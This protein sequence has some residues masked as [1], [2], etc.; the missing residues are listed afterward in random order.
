M[1]KRTFVRQLNSVAALGEALHVA[2]AFFVHVLQIMYLLITFDS[3]APFC[4]C[5]ERCDFIVYWTD[6]SAIH[7]EWFFVEVSISL[8]VRPAL[9][10]WWSLPN[11][12]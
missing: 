12:F 11:G 9:V 6:V 3:F 7:G 1:L 5:W 8:S 2:S 4:P 10:S